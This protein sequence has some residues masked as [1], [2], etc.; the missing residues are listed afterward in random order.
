VSIVTATR[1]HHQVEVGSSP[2]GSL[3]L[4]HAAQAYAATLG[5][6]FVLPDDVKTLAPYVLAHRIVLTPE[7]RARG[8]GDTAVVA[9]LLNRIPVPVGVAKE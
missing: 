4:L 7:T 2:R 5:R 3:A 8:I 1:E 9:D 6:D